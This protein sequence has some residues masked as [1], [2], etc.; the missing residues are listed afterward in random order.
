[1]IRAHAQVGDWIVGT[2]AKKNGLEG[3]L[4]YAMQVSEILTY[5]Q[6]WADKRFATKHP[7][8]RGSLKQAFGDNIYHRDDQGRWVQA[9]SHHSHEDGTPNEENIAHDTQS[10]TVLIGDAFY[11]WGA[12]GPIIPDQFRNYQGWDICHTGQGH[13]CNF[14]EALIQSFLQWLRTHRDDGFLGEPAEFK[15]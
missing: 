4:V 14:P 11:Y 7:N 2:G 10:E 12:S 1:M 6:Y 5:D 15:L 3:R 8:L 13:K 9:D